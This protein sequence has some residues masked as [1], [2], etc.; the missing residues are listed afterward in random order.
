MSAAEGFKKSKLLRLAQVDR[1]FCYTTAILAHKLWI[2][3]QPLVLF[4][5]FL[6]ITHILQKAEMLLMLGM[7]HSKPG[8]F[9]NVGHRVTSFAILCA[10]LY[11]PTL[12]FKLPALDFFSFG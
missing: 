3:D 7:G 12:A 8:N 10:N 5:I 11:L 6:N 1:M 4:K 9:N 2:P